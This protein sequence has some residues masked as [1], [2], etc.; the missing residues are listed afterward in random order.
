MR[1]IT[2]IICCFDILVSLFFG[3]LHFFV[4]P[5]LILSCAC[6][7]GGLWFLPII[8]FICCVFISRLLVVNLYLVLLSFHLI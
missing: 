8:V 7:C 4:W 2:D 1:P 5:A 3:Y 6:S